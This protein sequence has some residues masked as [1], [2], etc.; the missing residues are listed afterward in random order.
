MFIFIS[1]RVTAAW[2]V[3]LRRFGATQAVPKHDPAKAS[4]MAQRTR[5]MRMGITT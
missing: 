5:Q 3:G 1:L 2:T 4:T